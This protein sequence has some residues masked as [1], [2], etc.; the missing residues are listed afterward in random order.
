VAIGVGITLASLL[1]M[2]RMSETVQLENGKSLDR[3]AELDGEDL[4]QR[5][6]LPED[7]EVF[8][9]SGPVFF[10][11]AGELLDAMRKIGRAPKVVILRMRLVPMLDASGVTM[12]EEF[13]EQARVSGARIILSGVQSQPR[14]MLTRIGLPGNKSGISFETDYPAAL[15]LAKQLTKSTES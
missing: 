2:A 15:Q 12:I 6:D 11:V 8:R 5:D 14:E 9:I 1:F 3:D 10:G 4:D 7:V 13:I